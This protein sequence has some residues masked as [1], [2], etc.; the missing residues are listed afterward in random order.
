LPEV[1]MA[2]ALN[3][4]LRE[5]MRRDDS[6]VLLGEDIGKRGGVFLITEGLYEEFGP[7]RVLDT[8]LSESGIVGMAI[9]M[10]LYGLKPVAEI[11]FIDFA[12]MAYDQILN[13]LAKIRYRSGGQYE[14]PVVI[15]APC[16]AGVRGGFYHSQSPEAI[17][18]HTPGLRIVVPSSPYDAKGLLKTAIRGKDP[19]IFLEPKLLYRTPRE[20]VPE[21]DYTIPFGQA[22]VLRKGDH[23]TVITYG[24]TVYECVKAA[25]EAAR[26]G[27]EVEV[28]DL[29][30]L[31]PLDIETVLTSV[32][33]TGRAVLV[34]E[35]PRTGGFA[36]ELAALLAEKAI[37]YLAAPILRVTGPSVPQAP[38]SLEEL[39]MPSVPRIL[40]AIQRVA[41]Y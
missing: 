37:E 14:C 27:I 17:Y 16:G 2:K 4:A 39:Y 38:S 28:I 29:R 12:K 21:E 32:R 20:E 7:D 40:R 9:G 33:K 6:V 1:N 35:A 19:V 8:P 11:Q 24:T 31:I 34:H 18:A 22:R 15:R 25:E 5:E 26:F 13:Q 41:S 3:M 30:T 36:A 10:A 23:V